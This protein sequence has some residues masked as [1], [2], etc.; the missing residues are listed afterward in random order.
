M[1]VDPEGPAGSVFSKLFLE[2]IDPDVTDQLTADGVDEADTAGPWG[3]QQGEGGQWE[4]VAEG[5]GPAAVVSSYEIGLLI[6][7]ALPA[8]GRRFYRI[9]ADEAGGPGARVLLN[10]GEEP[11][12]QLSAVHED[13]LAAFLNVLEYLRRSPVDLARLMYAARGP[14]LKRAGT[15]LWLWEQ[16]AR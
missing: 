11:I 10:A 3:L 7:A 5:R 15:I 4:V 2:R 16:A 13:T 8:L 14:A 12:G 6:A 1:S 9:V